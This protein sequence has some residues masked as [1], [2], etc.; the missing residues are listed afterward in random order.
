MALPR[1]ILKLHLDLLFALNPGKLRGKRYCILLHS[2]PI[3]SH[4]M[5]SALLLSVAM[6]LS[7]QEH[8]L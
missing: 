4:C 7:I 3:R 5:R 6:V 1:C 8:H 2:L